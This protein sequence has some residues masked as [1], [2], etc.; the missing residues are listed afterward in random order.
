MISNNAGTVVL[1]QVGATVSIASINLAP[2]PPII[3]T[4]QQI[5]QQ[6]GG[7][8]RYLPP[9]PSGGDDSLVPGQQGADTP[10]ANQDAMESLANKL[11]QLDQAI[12]EGLAQQQIDAI[13]LNAFKDIIDTGLA[14]PPKTIQDLPPEVLQILQQQAGL[15]FNTANFWGLYI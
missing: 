3:I 11:A 12:A 5:Q 13:R 8:L 15:S 7:V 14:P 2:P 9:S 6:Y 4:A 1:N 10:P